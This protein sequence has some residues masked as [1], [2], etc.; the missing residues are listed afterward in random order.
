[1]LACREKPL[2]APNMSGEVQFQ[3]AHH[4]IW[5]SNRSSP[6]PLSPDFNLHTNPGNWN[7]EERASAFEIEPGSGTAV[8][9][10]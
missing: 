3:G 9:R 4:R 1:M 7:A 8:I 10:M 6:G 2:A 5:K